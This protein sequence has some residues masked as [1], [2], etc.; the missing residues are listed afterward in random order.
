VVF[1]LT[2]EFGCNVHKGGY[3]RIN[4][5]LPHV[6]IHQGKAV[7]RLYSARR[8]RLELSEKMKVRPF[9]LVCVNCDALG[10]VL[11]HAEYAPSST[12]V[13]C[14]GCGAPR[15]TLGDLRNLAFSDRTDILSG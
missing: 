10:I 1:S 15:G 14:R 12:Q 13:K 5:Q 4:G 6:R 7:G 3:I 9:Q 8:L 2:S 11:D